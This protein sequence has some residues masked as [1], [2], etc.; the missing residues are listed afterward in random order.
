MHARDENNTDRKRDRSFNQP[1]A[2]PNR[3]AA[4]W[5]EKSDPVT[6]DESVCKIEYCRMR[7]EAPLNRSVLS[8]LAIDD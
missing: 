1:R 3:S 8:P 5:K 2:V 6:Q 4:R 7:L